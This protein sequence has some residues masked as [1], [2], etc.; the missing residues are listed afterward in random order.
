MGAKK[1]P[2]TTMTLA[3]LGVDAA[4]VGAGAATTQVLSLEPAPARAAGTIVTDDGT[5]AEQITAFLGAR[6]LV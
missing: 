2:V 4:S 1:K 6:G 3:D 5:G